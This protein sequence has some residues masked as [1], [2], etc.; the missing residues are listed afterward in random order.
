MPK[1]AGSLFP[2]HL[3]RLGPDGS[4]PALALHCAL[5]HGGAW[6][7]VVEALDD[8]LSVTAPDM[9]GHGKSADWDRRCDFHDAVTALAEPML[10]DDIT[11]LGHSFGATIA[12]RLAQAHPGR[13]RRMVLIEPVLFAAAR[14]AAPK[15]FTERREASRPMMEA[16]A[17]GDTDTA[18][19]LFTGTWG[20]GKTWEEMSERARARLRKQVRIIEET[21]QALT[22]DSAGLLHEGALERCAMPIL[23][24][25]GAQTEPILGEI[26]AALLARLPDARE[27]LIPQ[28]GHMAPITAPDAVAGEIARFLDRT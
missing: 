17:R 2:V 13:I 21:E 6:T 22:W 4:A 5:A 14:E 8:R 25:R 9:P 26:H 20:V 11:L 10:Q 1:D 19:R 12:L 3:H 16:L 18:A 28:A 7:D 23:F 27:T 24:L 15:A